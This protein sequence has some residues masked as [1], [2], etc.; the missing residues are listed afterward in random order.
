MHSRA[1]GW[2]SEELCPPE[3]PRQSEDGP[4]IVLISQGPR[5]RALLLLKIATIAFSLLDTWHGEHGG[6]GI[7]STPD[8]RC[9]RVG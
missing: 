9:A 7:E 4:P 3:P 8:P 6:P 1:R 2:W 5:N